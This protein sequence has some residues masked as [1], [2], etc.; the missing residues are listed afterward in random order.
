MKLLRRDCATKKYTWRDVSKYRIGHPTLHSVPLS[1]FP[2]SVTRRHL[3]ESVLLCLWGG[4]EDVATR[5]TK[6]FSIAPYEQHCAHGSLTLRI[7]TTR[8]F[9]SLF[10]ISYTIKPAARASLAKLRH[11]CIPDHVL[12]SPPS[13]KPGHTMASSNDAQSNVSQPWRRTPLIHSTILSKHAGW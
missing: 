2:E 4:A 7:T 12:S 13:P 6:M 11:L 5:S 1:V 8:K 10:C 9:Y 3:V